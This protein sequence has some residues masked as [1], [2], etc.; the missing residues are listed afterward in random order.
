MS[1]VFGSAVA[2]RLLIL[3]IL[4]SL[5]DLSTDILNAL[6]MILSSQGICFDCKS[7]FLKSFINICQDNATCIMRQKDIGSSALSKPTMGI[8][9]IIIIF[10]PGMV[11]AFKH[12]MTCLQKKEYKKVPKASCYLPFPLYVLFV[13]IKA[14]I[15]PLNSEQ[16]LIRVLSMEA[17]YESF[18]QL[19]LQIIS[20]IYSYQLSYIQA[21][22]IAFSLL[23]LAKTVILLDSAEPI[24]VVINDEMELSNLSNDVHDIENLT[25]NVID[26]NNQIEQ[27]V[28]ENK[29]SGYCTTAFSALISVL[30]YMVW[31]LPLYLTSIIFKI[32]SFSI[33]F[34]YLRVYASVTMGLLIIELF[35]LA[36][37]TGFRKFADRIYPVFSNFFIVNIGGA[38][39]REREIM[40]KDELEQHSTKYN[41][42]YK[43]AKRSVLL[44]YLH[45][46]LVLILIA[47]LVIHVGK[48]DETKKLSKVTTLNG[49]IFSQG[50]N[51]NGIVSCAYKTI[52][53]TIADLKVHWREMHEWLYPFC[54]Y[55]DCG[56][57]RGKKN[58]SGE[59]LRLYIEEIVEEK[60]TIEENSKIYPFMIIIS[61]IILVGL[62]NLMLSVYSARDIKERNAGQLDEIQVDERDE[63]EPF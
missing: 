47:L 34:A 43:F 40:N 1:C 16:R 6:D 59:D 12:V 15:D 29:A 3:S 14:V 27:D 58:V 36:K 57:K 5:L 26:D 52:N 45:H 39:I 17:F 2:I 9:S 18:P 30:R 33:T 63:R 28:G 23:M 60:I 61:S 46:T 35:V 19:V 24:R 22:S 38:Q 25:E 20:I 32:A 11:K 54:K 42:M 21:V 62:L 7:A 44:S 37:Y 55:Q 8:I 53:S 13:Q 50:N 51:C 56:Q 31:V 10:L 4:P 41:D 48:V 49:T